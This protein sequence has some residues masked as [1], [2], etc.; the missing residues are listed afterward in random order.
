MSLGRDGVT[1]ALKSGA[2]GVPSERGAFDSHRIFADAREDS[3]FAKIGSGQPVF[4]QKTMKAFE[5]FL[6][7][8]QRFA[9]QGIGHQGGRRRGDC[10]AHALKGN[11]GHAPVNQLELK[12]ETVAAQRVVAIG[13]MGSFP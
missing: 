13:L 7:L 6:S 11:L 5:D 1:I 10:A 9:F 8:F 4:G 12:R 2:H 3:E